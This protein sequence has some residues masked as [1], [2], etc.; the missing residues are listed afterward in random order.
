MSARHLLAIVKLHAVFRIANTSRSRMSDYESC[1]V[2]I[3]LVS[4]FAAGYQRYGRSPRAIRG[5]VILQTR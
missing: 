2:K 4:R 1:I 3:R 5:A